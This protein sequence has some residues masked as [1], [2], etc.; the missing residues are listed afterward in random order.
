MSKY[1]RIFT[2]GRTCGNKFQFSSGYGDNRKSVKLWID[3]PAIAIDSDDKTFM[4]IWSWGLRCNFDCSY[5]SPERHNNNSKHTNKEN[6]LK[7]LIFSR[8]T[9]DEQLY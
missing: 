7:L 8:N 9:I 3:N 5:C 1:K 6:L 2:C 4:V